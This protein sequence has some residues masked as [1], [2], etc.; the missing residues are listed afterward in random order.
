MH[1]ISDCVFTNQ[2]QD[3]FMYLQN[4]ILFPGVILLNHLQGGGLH[5]TARF[6][7]R[8]KIEYGLIFKGTDQN[9]G[10]K[11]IL[12]LLIYKGKTT[13]KNGI[14]LERYQVKKEV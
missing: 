8:I 14:F 3:S 9:A 13:E 10:T 2:V 11:M 1:G 7:L 5:L 12:L 4:F 6:N